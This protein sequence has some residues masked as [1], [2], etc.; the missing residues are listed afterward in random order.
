MSNLSSLSL[1]ALALA[2][3]SVPAGNILAALAMNA[4][5]G[6]SVDG[7]SFVDTLNDLAPGAVDLANKTLA[8]TRAIDVLVR[9]H[10][11][12]DVLAALKASAAKGDKATGASRETM[13]ANLFGL[14]LAQSPN[15]API[16]IKRG[17]DAALDRCIAS[18]R[19]DGTLSHDAPYC[20]GKGKG[21]TKPTD[22]QSAAVLHE[23]FKAEYEAFLKEQ[24]Q[25]VSAAAARD[26]QD[27]QDEPS[28][29]TE[30]LG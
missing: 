7:E 22:N 12:R 15:E 17:V 23:K 6:D 24:E 28:D 1:S 4:K 29:S 10:V 19:D 9:Y 20:S 14:L 18:R 25:A 5:K 21:G 8:E 3:V 26:E 27:S 13:A 16:D 2:L 11:S 30:S